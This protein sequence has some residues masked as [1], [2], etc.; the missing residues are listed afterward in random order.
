LEIPKP[1]AGMVIR[2]GY[3]WYEEAM[4]G[5][6]EARKDRPCSVVLAMQLREAGI[7]V[8]VAPITH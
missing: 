7:M 1:E 8:L 5:R 6:E 3:L 2:Y 4:E